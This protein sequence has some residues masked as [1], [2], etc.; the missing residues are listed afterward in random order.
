VPTAVLPFARIVLRVELHLPAFAQT[1]KAGT[2]QHGGVS[3][4]VLLSVIRRGRMHVG[5][6]ARASW[7]FS[8]FVDLEVRL[9]RAVR[10]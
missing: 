6:G 1:V 7:P 3:E 9:K 5:S 4:D 8:R 2:L 10:Q